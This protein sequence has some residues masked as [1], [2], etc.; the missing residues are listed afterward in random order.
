M[1][2][3]QL[4]KINLKRTYRTSD[5]SEVKLPSLPDLP[6]MISPSEMRYLYWLTGETFLGMGEVVEVGTW[7]GRSTS[8]IAAGVNKSSSSRRLWCYDSYEWI[9]AFNF[10][11][12]G[13]DYNLKAGDDFQPQFLKNV[14][15]VSDKIISIKAPISKISWCKAPIEILILDAPKS[16]QD[17]SKCLTVFAPYL[18][19][20][21]S[22]VVLQDYCYSPSYGISTVVA[23]NQWRLEPVHWVTPSSMATFKVTAGFDPQT[24]PDPE[25]NFD[26]WEPAKIEKAW[27]KILADAPEPSRSLLAP[28]LPFLLYDRN[29]NK[30]ALEIVKNMEFT[31][32]G[33]ARWNFLRT[34]PYSFNR[35][36]DLFNARPE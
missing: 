22:V 15:S 33:W 1:N 13:S 16:R 34:N 18:I 24:V 36:T 27:E 12:D 6:G 20:G 25:W 35:Y 10:K 8:C 32:E 29:E 3:H 23:A 7:L 26:A 19:P 21:I 5:F 30:R 2:E 28:G 17:I 4:K 9:E 14:S 11:V 31:E